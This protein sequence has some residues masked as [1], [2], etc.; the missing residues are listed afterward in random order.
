MSGGELLVPLSATPP[1]GDAG[2]FTAL[3]MSLIGTK[4]LFAALQHYVG[5]WGVKRTQ[6]GLGVLGR[7]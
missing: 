1:P 2:F 6:R 5:Y 7:S 4:L 3:H